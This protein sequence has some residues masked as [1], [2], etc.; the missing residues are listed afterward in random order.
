MTTPPCE[1]APGAVSARAERSIEPA[2][3]TATLRCGT[4]VI[5]CPGGLENGGGIGRQMSYFLGASSPTEL[6]DY[7]VVDTRGPWFLGDARGRTA[8]SIG[9]LLRSAAELIA[10][11]IRRQPSLLH[12]NITG[13]GSTIRKSILCALARFLRLPYLLHVHDP[14]YVSGY[15]RL[16]KP[17]RWFV[18]AAFRKSVAVLVLG[19][20]ER[21]RFTTHLGLPVSQ[22]RVLHNAVPDPRPF[23][24]PPRNPKDPCRILFLGHLS[25]RKGVPELLKALATPTLASRSW[26]ATI[27][28][29]GAIKTYRLKA[30]QLAI[31]SR[32][33][34]PG[35]LGPDEVA[36][37]FAAA[38]ILVLP[39]HAEG[40]AIA[41]LE[42]LSY[43][44]AVITTKV[45]A[46]EEVIE[47]GASGLFVPPGDIDALASEIAGLIDDSRAR[48]R[49]GAGG[50]RRYEE[51]FEM[52]RYR[53]TLSQ[54][55]LDCLSLTRAGP[56]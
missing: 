20:G 33:S 39:S 49:L 2:C 8:A 32:V 52:T 25:E 22:V 46:H 6:L 10:L 42:A 31:A 40:L 47:P 16:P 4:V 44:V 30:E 19:A 51:R 14:D 15:L 24:Q 35:W 23:Q 48:E 36:P 43:G 37:L 41:V 5:L 1:L 53:R 12:V 54:T 50:R 18:R 38:D 7:R 56:P 11:R 17:F 9:F 27:A 26:E 28:G 13:R 3:Q 45:G 21:S 34:F 55:H 29:G